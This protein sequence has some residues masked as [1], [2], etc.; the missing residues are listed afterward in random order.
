MRLNSRVTRANSKINLINTWTSHRSPSDHLMSKALWRSHLDRHVKMKR[1]STPIRFCQKCWWSWI[2]YTWKLRLLPNGMMGHTTLSIPK[3]TVNMFV[4]I[5]NSTQ[6]EIF[7]HQIEDRLSHKLKQGSVNK[8]PSL[9]PSALHMGANL[10]QLVNK[11][12]DLIVKKH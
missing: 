5:V 9:I 1:D 10:K 2:T 6:H 3:G 4:G 7:L 8:T 11:L 12:E